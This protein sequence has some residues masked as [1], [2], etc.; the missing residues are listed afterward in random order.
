MFLA[1]NR[2]VNK[3]YSELNNIMGGKGDA[4][5]APTPPKLNMCSSNTPDGLNIPQ[6]GVKMYYSDGWTVSPY[7]SCLKNLL[8]W[9]SP[10]LQVQFVQVFQRRYSGQVVFH[11]RT[12]K[13]YREGFGDMNTEFW[14]GESLPFFMSVWF[15]YY[16]TIGMY[17]VSRIVSDC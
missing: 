16:S 2:S 10:L 3:I 6:S 15:Q 7:I 14:L 11:T 5:Q 9:F 17:H 13:E 1:L 8:L 4:A 12:W